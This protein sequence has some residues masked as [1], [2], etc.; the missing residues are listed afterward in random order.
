MRAAEWRERLR[1]TGE[2]CYYE[3]NVLRL[4]DNTALGFLT[5]SQVNISLMAQEL[6]DLGREGWRLVAAYTN[7]LGKNSSAFGGLGMNATVDEHI[8]IFERRVQL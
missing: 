5:G 7:E 3:Y 6:N 2:D 8:L 1:R 4:E